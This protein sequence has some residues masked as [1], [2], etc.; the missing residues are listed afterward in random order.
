MGKNMKT[1]I[2]CSWLY[3]LGHTIFF[4][5]YKMLTSIR[6]HET[7]PN[8]RPTSLEFANNTDKGALDLCAS[9]HGRRAGLPAAR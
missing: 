4:F 5:D 2:S 1:N 6:N 8:S 7:P 3:F 9:V